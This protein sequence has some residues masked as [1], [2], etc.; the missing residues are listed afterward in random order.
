MQ[1]NNTS[2][3]MAYAAP[4]NG[5]AY[6]SSEGVCPSTLP[7]TIDPPYFGITSS[8]WS[9]ANSTFSLAAIS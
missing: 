2:L 5:M 4:K 3:P 1:A 9:I 6:S 8:S 7:M